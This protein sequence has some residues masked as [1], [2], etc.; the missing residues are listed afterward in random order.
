MRHWWVGDEEIRVK[1]LQ[2]AACVHE[3]FVL[4][5]HGLAEVG[6]PLRSLLAK[7]ECLSRDAGLLGLGLLAGWLVG[8]PA[9]CQWLQKKWKAV[10]RWAC[11]R[12]Q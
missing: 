7:R 12:T 2:K 5:G 3:G 6:G 9:G 11:S 1:A 4:I 8:C 10:A